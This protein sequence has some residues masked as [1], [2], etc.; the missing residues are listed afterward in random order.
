MDLVSIS[1]VEQMLEKCGELFVQ[2]YYS[3]EERELFACK[4]RHAEHFLAGRFAAKEALLKAIGTG[5]NCELDW[6]ELEFLNHPGGQPYLVR[7]RSLEPYVQQQD[8]IHVS[9][10][11]HGDYAA[12]FIIIESSQ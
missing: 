9:I 8:S 4:K 3:M 2:Q 6:N 10:S 5:M 7:S 1:F 11:H 12:A